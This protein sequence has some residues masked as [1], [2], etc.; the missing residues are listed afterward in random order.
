V[1]D[2]YIIQDG[3]PF[4]WGISL[5]VF[6]TEE[7]A[8]ALLA[9]LN[10]KGVHSARLGIHSVTAAKTVYQLRN[11]N[12]G[13]IASLDK[14]TSEFPHIDTHSCDANANGNANPDNKTLAHTAPKPIYPRDAIR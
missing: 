2:F 4:H 3:G 6:K 5:G 11:I 10:Q 14:I 8:R 13:T 1:N 7:A 9:A 12:A